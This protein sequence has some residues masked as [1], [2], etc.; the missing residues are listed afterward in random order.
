MPVKV[1][2][3]RRG[4]WAGGPAQRL[5]GQCLLSDAACLGA[6]SSVLQNIRKSFLGKRFKLF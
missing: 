1:R 2:G 6:V 4:P 5:C 3:D